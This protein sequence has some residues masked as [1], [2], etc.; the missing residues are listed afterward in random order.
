MGD[1]PKRD[2]LIKIGR[3]CPRFTVFSELANQKSFKEMIENMSST[4]TEEFK[5]C[6]QPTFRSSLITQMEV[7]DDPT[8]TQQDDCSINA[9]LF[10]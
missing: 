1:G 10:I 3:H 4:V 6:F 7:V 8:V 9:E 2:I 5:H